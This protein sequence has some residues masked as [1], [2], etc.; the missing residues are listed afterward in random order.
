M[1]KGYPDF[2]GYSV[3]PQYGPYQFETPAFAA[4]AAG[5]S[6]NLFSISGKGVLTGGFIA[7]SSIDEPA[8][9]HIQM[10]PDGV[11]SYDYLLEYY[12]DYGFN[13]PATGMFFA[14]DYEAADGYVT[15]HPTPGLTFSS[16][17]VVYVSN[18]AAGAINIASNIWWQ[19][20]V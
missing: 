4:L 8:N 10:K 14:S 11:D 20:L 18:N 5:I 3:F 6:G 17:L 19:R 2:F 7:F 12:K 9:V 1:A 16:S 13:F 15:L